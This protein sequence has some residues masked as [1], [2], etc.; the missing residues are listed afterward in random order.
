MR[1]DLEG[2]GRDLIEVLSRDLPGGTEAKPQR[3]S[4]RVDAVPTRD[5]NRTSPE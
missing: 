2:N 3:T 1:K 4:V 5:S